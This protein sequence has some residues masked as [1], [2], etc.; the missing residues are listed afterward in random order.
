VSAAVPPPEERL[1][2]PDAFLSRSDL[3][4]LGLPRR[5]VDAIFRASEVVVLPG[6]SRPL[7]TVDEYRRVIEAATYRGDRV[8]PT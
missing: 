5:A 1:E 8:R 6:Y 2:R 4:A 7:I 3:A